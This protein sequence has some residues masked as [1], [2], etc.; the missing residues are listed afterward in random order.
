MAA[1]LLEIAGGAARR[2]RFWQIHS[3]G[4]GGFGRPATRL[5]QVVMQ[6]A[7]LTCRPS[8]TAD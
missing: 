7:T 3:A 6:R 5:S 2:I 4:T 8:I 1:A